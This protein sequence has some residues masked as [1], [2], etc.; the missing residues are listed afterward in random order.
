MFF[1]DTF[2]SICT[3]IVGKARLEKIIQNNDIFNASLLLAQEYCQDI[4]TEQANKTFDKIANEIK[5]RIDGIDEPKKIVGV[6]NDYLFDEYQIQSCGSLVI[7]N[8][9]VDKVLENK[10][11]HCLG[12]SILY[13]ALAERLQLPVFAKIVPSHV[14]LCYD[15]G[16]TK[17]NIETTIKGFSPP[18]SYYSYH[19]PYPEEHQTIKKLSKREV[20]GLFLNNMGA[21]LRQHPNAL[22]IQKKALKLFPDCENINT[23]TGLVL[24]KLNELKKA[25]KNL[26]K[27]IKLDPTS[28]QPHLK[29]GD[30]YYVSSDYKQ[31]SEAYA[32]SINLLRKSAKILRYV[33]GLPEKEILNK[34][35]KEMLQ[36]REVP[37]EQLI[38]IGIG[39][40][41][42]EEYGLSNELFVRAL[43]ECPEESN[44]HVYC[45]ITS[46]H[47]GKYEKAREYAQHIQIV[48]E[49]E[50]QTDLS[51]LQTMEDNPALFINTI[52]DCYMKL[53]Q[54]HAFLKR[55]ELAFNEINKAI[56]IGGM[57]FQFLCA[58]AGTNLLKGDKVEAKKYYKKAMELDP[59]NEWI[60]EQ[61]SNLQSDGKEI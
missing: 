53:G 40:F 37:Y 56:E 39:L 57:K 2:Q 41:Q 1:N 27:A 18:D 8:I 46:F 22:N 17:F 60:Q 28:W 47:L 52:A 36:L 9:L 54:S 26:K 10:K 48:D 42:Q 14:Y 21:Y 29:I 59:S 51:P 13:L 49:P 45:A 61:L 24:L 12:L 23:N 35:A 44:I 32:E 20:L 50:W 15:N 19:F 34:V 4:N 43:R 16:F 6:I 7:E 33:Q 31:A 55:Y 30:L 25:K 3:D 11:G 5:S 58:I 38:G